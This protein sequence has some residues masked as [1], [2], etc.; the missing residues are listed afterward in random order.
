MMMMM[1]MA[2][3]ICRAS[4]KQAEDHAVRT[5]TLSAAAATGNVDRNAG[6]RSKKKTNSE[7]RGDRPM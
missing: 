2:T 4:D 5:K 7:V 3:Y 6:R 1:M